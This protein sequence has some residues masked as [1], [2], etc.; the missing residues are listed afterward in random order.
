MKRENAKDPE[1]FKDIESCEALDLE[2]KLQKT[3]L[4]NEKKLSRLKEKT[5]SCK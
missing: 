2:L 5:L 3:Q 1:T 4:K